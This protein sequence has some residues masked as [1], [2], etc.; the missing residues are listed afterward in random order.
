MGFLKSKSPSIR[1]VSIFSWLW[2]QKD[3]KGSMDC[4]H[5]LMTVPWIFWLCLDR[6]KPPELQCCHG[7]AHVLCS[8]ISTTTGDFPNTKCNNF[9]KEHTRQ[10]SVGFVMIKPSRFYCYGV[11]HPPKCIRALPSWA[12]APS[13][14]KEMAPVKMVCSGNFVSSSQKFPGNADWKQ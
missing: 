9:W 7:L 1:V 2:P 5:F 12:C 13:E 4:K 3:V 6:W 14:S 11:S 8:T 10:K